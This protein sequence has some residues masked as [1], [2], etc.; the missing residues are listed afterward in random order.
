MTGEDVSAED[1]DKCHRLKKKSMVIIKFRLHK[2]RDEVL[3]NRKNLKNKRN[4]TGDMGCGKSFIKESSCLQ[5]RGLGY[6]CRR[7]KKDEKIKDSYFYNG[8][9]FVIE[10]DGKKVQIEHLTDTYEFSSEEIV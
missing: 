5:Y 1:F 4:E 10:N 9:L 6:A 2:L 8:R 3:V 7:L